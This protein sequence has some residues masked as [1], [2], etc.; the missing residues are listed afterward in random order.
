MYGVLHR[1][2]N[3]LIGEV[4]AKGHFASVRVCYSNKSRKPL[5]AKLMSKKTLS[6]TKDLLKIIFNERFLAPI[7]IHPN[8]LEIAEVF[9]TQQT[10][11]QIS[12]FYENGSLLDTIQNG[13][14]IRNELDGT[15][16]T[17]SLSFENKLKITCDILSA[18][19]YLHSH[20]ICHRDIKLENILITDNLRAKLCDFGLATISFDGNVSGRCGSFHYVSPECLDI[21]KN[22][23]STGC[24]KNHTYNGFASDIWSLG[25]LLYALFSNK[26]PYPDLDVNQSFEE[27]PD[28]SILPPELRP[29][30]ISLLNKDPTQRPDIYSICELE[31]FKPYLKLVNGHYNYCSED[32]IIESKGFL[33]MLKTPIS[34]CLIES[35]IQARISQ[36]LNISFSDCEKKLCEKEPCIEKLFYFLLSERLE[37]FSGFTTPC[38]TNYLS[39]S[40]V[41]T[42][43]L[44]HSISSFNQNYNSRRVSNFN[45]L[46]VS[47]SCPSELLNDVSVKTYKASSKEVMQYVHKFVTAKNGCITEPISPNREIVLNGPKKDLVLSFECLDID[48]EGDDT[49]ANKR[50]DTY[51]SCG[52]D[53]LLTKS[54]FTNELFEKLSQVF[55]EA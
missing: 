45:S 29:V 42:T 36:M 16:K 55:K 17:I 1:I 41:Q 52:C 22:E 46:Q 13:I 37:K 5:C 14:E 38:S 15:K 47:S 18:L 48:H 50:R 31:V 54:E 21:L 25:V 4:V 7:L 33:E 30:I 28:F 49:F 53:L 44:D 35:F 24:S 40:L 19:Y 32:N 34:P 20:C 26:L 2:H 10:I 51:D 9:D 3:Y 39:N 23:A 6:K 12:K 43:S 8:I 11:F 27:D